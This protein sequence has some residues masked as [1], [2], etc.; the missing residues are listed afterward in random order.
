MFIYQN[1][2]VN[3]F[4]T[5]DRGLQDKHISIECFYGSFMI[6][7]ETEQEHETELWVAQYII[8]QLV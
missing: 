8:S 5:E 3:I 2:K 1:K 7:Q 4:N 6:E